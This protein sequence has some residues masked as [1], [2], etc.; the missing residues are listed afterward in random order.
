MEN[1]CIGLTLCIY[2]HTIALLHPSGISCMLRF[3]Y[4]LP[5]RDLCVKDLP[6]GRYIQ[7]LMGKYLG[8]DVLYMNDFPEKFII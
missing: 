7:S 2:C 6:L 8:K 1:T 5:S 4:K 3:G